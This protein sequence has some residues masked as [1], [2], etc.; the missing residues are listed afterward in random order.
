RTIRRNANSQGQE[1]PNG[2]EVQPPQRDVTYVE[3]RNAIHMVTQV[4]ENHVGQLGVGHQDVVD[5]SRILWH[6]GYEA[7]LVQSMVGP[8]QLSFEMAQMVF[9]SVVKSVTFRE[10]SQR[11]G[12]V[13]AIIEPNLLQQ[14]EWTDIL[15]EELLKGQPEEQTICMLWFSMRSSDHVEKGKKD[16][17][18]EV[19]QLTHL[20]VRLCNTPCPKKG[21][22]TN[23]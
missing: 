1:D 12:T 6:K 16:L 9:L 23:S 4:V 7:H 8:T 22:E 20:G 14:L 10:I 17:A 13:T 18:K 21:N 19:H 3:L 15:R 5:T 2:P 11:G